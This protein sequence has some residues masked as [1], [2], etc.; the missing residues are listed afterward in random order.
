[1]HEISIIQS[2]LD[3]AEEQARGAGS[4]GI[5]SVRLRV[6]IVSSVV[7]E[8]LEFAFD[9][10][11]KGTMAENATLEIERVPA[12]AR[13]AGCGKTF[14]LDRIQFD[15]PECNGML[16]LGMGGADL[17]LASLVLL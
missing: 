14:M 10:L 15:C 3:L 5:I 6:G 7:P 2:T 1:M 16:I 8:T 9:V 12:E 11:K 4:E 13:C 17:E